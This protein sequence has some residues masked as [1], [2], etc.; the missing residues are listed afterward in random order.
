MIEIS[1]FYL[2]LNAVAFVFF[3]YAMCSSISP[4]NILIYPYINEFFRSMEVD[5][6]GIIIF[7]VMFT[8]VFLPALVVYFI[9]IS[10]LLIL[11]LI[12]IYITELFKKGK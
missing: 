9:F 12:I 11:T 5:K 7:D 10:V 4:W 6:T 3:C 2:G 1:S 8:L